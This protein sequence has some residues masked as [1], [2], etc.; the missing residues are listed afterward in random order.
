M[1]GIHNKGFPLFAVETVGAE[2]LATFSNPLFFN[3]FTCSA[4]LVISRESYYHPGKLEV[5]AL[6]EQE[7]LSPSVS[8]NY[9]YADII[10]IFYYFFPFLLIALKVPMN[11]IAARK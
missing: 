2:R 4:R 10:I 8:F 1:A 3:L 11:A 7:T 5:N 6:Y 9:G